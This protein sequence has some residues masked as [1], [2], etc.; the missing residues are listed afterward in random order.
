MGEPKTSAVPLVGRMRPS[1]RR[2]SVD[3]PDAIRSDEADHACVADLEIE[4]SDRDDVAEAA[5][6]L[7]GANDGQVAFLGVC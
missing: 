4:L 3:L 2:M 6:E 1:N 5:C 7:L